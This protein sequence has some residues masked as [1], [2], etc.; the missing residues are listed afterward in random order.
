MIGPAVLIS[1]GITLAKS[2]GV[3]ESGP[4][5]I[6]YPLFVF[7][8]ISIWQVFAESLDIA[9]QAYISARSYLTR[10]CFDHEVIVL[11]QL[12]ENLVSTAVRLLAAIICVLLF[13]H[14]SIAGIAVLILAFACTV[15][16]GLAV[17][18]LIL[19]VLIL[20][21]DSYSA[22]RLFISYGLFLTP[23]LYNPAADGV[24]SFIVRFNP[25]TPLMSAAR[26]G[27]GGHTGQAFLTLTVIGLAA[28]LLI[29]A[30]RSLLR[31]AVP[32]MIERMLLGGK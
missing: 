3:I 9:Y 27:A 26:A 18:M 8:G 2:S 25:L 17:G 11:A 1:M 13:A 31:T 22:L 24:F 5:E 12:Y 10:V 14:T 19:P 15:A 23:A 30:G 29:L 6:S 32:I 20:F 4:T 16:L 21:N 7:I 28:L